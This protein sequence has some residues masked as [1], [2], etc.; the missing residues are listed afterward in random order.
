MQTLE[1]RDFFFTIHKDEEGKV[2]GFSLQGNRHESEC[3]SL[4][5]I[6]AQR[7][8][9]A[10]VEVQEKTIVF[11]HD[12]ASD[13]NLEIY[14]YSDG[15][16]VTFDIA[17][18]DAEQLKQLLARSGEYEGATLSAGFELAWGKGFRLTAERKRVTA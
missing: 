13:D 7:T 8:H 6:T 9:K 10:L 5:F 3:Y 17:P 14:G 4:T 15:G 1:P 11:K 2:S 16:G 18:E 12:G